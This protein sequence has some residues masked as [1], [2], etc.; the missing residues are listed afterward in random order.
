[1]ACIVY[2]TD[3]QGRKYAYSS[4]SY[5][6][7]EKGQSRSR[8]T[9]LG[10]VNPETGEIIKGRKDGKNYK[11]RPKDQPENVDETLVSELRASL[12]KKGEEVADLQEENRKLKEQVR[13]LT[14]LCREI[15]A[16][17]SSVESLVD[18]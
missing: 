5:W 3:S 9:Y 12:Q 10:R 17:A 13:K 6:D 8:R 15:A 4:E 18:E 16:R 1:M 2:R 7:K 11:A 14:K